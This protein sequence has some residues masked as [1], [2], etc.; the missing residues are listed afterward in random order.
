ML[1]WGLKWDPASWGDTYCVHSIPYP[2]D[3]GIVGFHLKGW[4]RN[5]SSVNLQMGEI[6]MREGRDQSPEN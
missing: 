6:P 3:A 5:P 1:H 4:R 2:V